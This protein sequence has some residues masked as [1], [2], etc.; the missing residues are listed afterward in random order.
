MSRHLFLLAF[1][2]A[3]L[4]AA[5]ALAAESRPNV[6]FIAVDDLNDWIGCL[7]G[8]PDSKTP[9]LDRLAARGTNF[10]NAHCAAPACNPS[11]AALMTG[12]RPWTSGVY[13]NSQP[14]RPVMPDVVT[15]S[16]HFMKHGYEA[17][18]GGKIFHGSFKEDASWESYAPSFSGPKAP[19]EVQN[20]PHSHAGGIIWGKLDA[21]DS[22]M[23]DYKLVS[24]AVDYL[25]QDH[26]RPFF[27]ACGLIR[28]H[29]PWQVPSK[30]YD[31]YPLDKI[32][33]PEVPDDD[34]ADVPPAGVKVA[35]P[36]GDH[37][38]ILK[39]DNW[40]YAVQGYLATIA[41]ADAQIGRLLEGL[42]NSKHRDNTIIVLWGDHGWHL[43]EKK[44]WRK[45]ALWEEATR[46]PLIIAAPGKKPA[47]CNRPVDF[48]SI[49]PT[50]VELCGLPEAKHV[51][52]P[53]LVPLLDNAKAPWDRPAITTH[54]RGNHAVRSEQ[55][56]YIRYADGSEE[57]Y[58]HQ[59]DPMEWKNLADDPR[60]ASIKRDLA[61]YL[62]KSEAQNAPAEREEG[63][64]ARRRRAR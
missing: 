17:L 57:L 40:R 4:V 21:Q 61:A 36:E 20:D 29:M 49:Y 51:E 25:K 18:G 33:L 42:D 15:L 39:T 2:G 46:A 32:T 28:P 64:R 58:D 16:Q 11:R 31:M 56:R 22:D 34:L 10:T 37:A 47:V 5:P 14:W 62:P 30:Y 53:S 24:W 45:F 44:H 23:T 48:M 27:L 13:N 26:D 63:N 3:V 60:H 1:V 55:Y 43:G 35:R 19:P 38:N 8:H 50:L 7:G 54:G 6:L 12:K 9:N 41:F 59:S 52:G